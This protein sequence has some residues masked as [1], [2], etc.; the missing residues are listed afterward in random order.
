MGTYVI[1]RRQ[2]DRTWQETRMSDGSRKVYETATEAQRTL[3]IYVVRDRRHEYRVKVLPEAW[4][5]D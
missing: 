2:A 3:D 4:K 5:E 1:V